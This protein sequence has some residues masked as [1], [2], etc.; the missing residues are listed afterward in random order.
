MEGRTVEKF[1]RLASSGS[2]GILKVHSSRGFC[3]P[4]ETQFCF[5]VN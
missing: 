1:N 4:L 5:K 2:L 3:L